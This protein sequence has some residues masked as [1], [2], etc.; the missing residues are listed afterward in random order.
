M[1]ADP[2]SDGCSVPPAGSTVCPSTST[3]TEEQFRLVGPPLTS[4]R[5]KLRVRVVRSGVPG[6][7]P[8]RAQLLASWLL[9]EW[10]R[11]RKARRS[12][13]L[14]GHPARTDLTSPIIEPLPFK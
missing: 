13:Q 14:Q 12:S 1:N 8:R 5:D 11:E 4:G 2:I 3:Q 6:S 10:E 7:T 9:A